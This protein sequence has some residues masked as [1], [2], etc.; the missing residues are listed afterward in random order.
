[1]SESGFFVPYPPLDELKDR[2]TFRLRVLGFAHLHAQLNQLTDDRLLAGGV[3]LSES[4]AEEEA[5][6]QELMRT[7]RE[8]DPVLFEIFDKL[9]PVFANCLFEC[10]ERGSDVVFPSAHPASVSRDPQQ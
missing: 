6:C 7:A 8:R 2:Q 1:M 9:K 10:S 4:L 5:Q 3:V